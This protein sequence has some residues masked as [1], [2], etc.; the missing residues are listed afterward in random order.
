MNLDKLQC[1][2]VLSVSE[3]AEK[4]GFTLGNFDENSTIEDVQN[5]AD[6]ERDLSLFDYPICEIDMVFTDVNENLVLVYDKSIDD[7]RLCE[8]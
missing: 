6:D 1:D 5:Y 3:Y 4:L 7:I 8:V 2:R